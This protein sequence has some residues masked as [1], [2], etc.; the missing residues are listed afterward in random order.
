M[1]ASD[2]GKTRNRLSFAAH[3]S[4]IGLFKLGGNDELGGRMVPLNSQHVGLA[5]DLAIFHVRL[6]PSRGFVDCREVPLSARR[7]L[8]SRFHGQKS[9]PQQLRPRL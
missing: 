9:L 8:K 7:A 1:G 6:A 2:L 5:A 4:G 3:R